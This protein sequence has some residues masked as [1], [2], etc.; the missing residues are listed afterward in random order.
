MSDKVYIGHQEDYALEDLLPTI[1]DILL[2]G[3]ID[4]KISRQ[5]T[6][7]LKPNMLSRS[8]PDKAV[9]T[10]PAVLDCVI[11]VLKEFGAQPQNITVADSSGGTVNRSVLRGNYKTCGFTAV[12]EKHGVVLYTDQKGVFVKTDGKMVKEFEL[13][14]PAVNCDVKISL[15]K[16]KTHVMTGMSGAVKNLFGTVPGLKKAE[17]HMRFPDKDNFCNM[18]VDLCETVKPDFTIID[19][20]LGMDGDGPGGGNPK[21]FKVLLA[22][23]NPY[24]IDLAVCHMMGTPPI[25]FPI[26]RAAIERSLA[27]SELPDGYIEGDTEDYRVIEG[28]IKPKSYNVDFSD[29]VP[30]IFRWMTPILEKFLVPR[31]KINTGKCIGCGRCRDICPQNT[32]AITNGKARIDP[33]NCIRCFCC[34]EMC[35]AKAIDVKKRGVFNI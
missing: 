14:E 34:H 20:I 33:K 1:R 30:Y 2:W 4:R 3:G 17:F 13:I 22:G 15:A 28:F 21:M 32:I 11:T 7:L 31:P 9:T 24:Y 16:F 23:A 12:C 27:P 26:M 29:Q 8:A 18:M 25:E 10:N 19:G 6:V 35:P 5:T